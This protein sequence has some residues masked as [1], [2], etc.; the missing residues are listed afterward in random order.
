MKG[1]TV[2]LIEIAEKGLGKKL[3]SDVVKAGEYLYNKGFLLEDIAKAYNT[4]KIDL[5]IEIINEF[6][7]TVEEE[8]LVYER[9]KFKGDSNKRYRY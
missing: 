7:K 9:S 4:T 1:Q 5:L 2:N 6:Q 8:G 3:A